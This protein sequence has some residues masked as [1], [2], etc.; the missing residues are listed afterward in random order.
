M[1]LWMVLLLVCNAL[2]MSP[3]AAQAEFISH[4]LTVKVNLDPND[5]TSTYSAYLTHYNGE[6]WDAPIYPV[7]DQ[8]D[9]TR[10]FSG[11]ESGQQY[12]LH[13]DTTR[14]QDSPYEYYYYFKNINITD[15]DLTHTAELISNQNPDPLYTSF[16]DNNFMAGKVAG[17]LVWG[18]PSMEDDSFSFYQVYFADSSGNIIPDVPPVAVRSKSETTTINE[19][20]GYRYMVPDTDIP[21]GAEQLR[22]YKTSSLD[23]TEKKKTPVFI[24]LRDNPGD[25]LN[26]VR[27]IDANKEPG[28]IQ[29]TIHW[30]KIGNESRI[31]HYAIY[32]RQMG[33]FRQIGTVRASGE[34]SYSL[35]LPNEY[36]VGI[37]A[38][39][40]YI[41]T[42]DW[43]GV[44]SYY[45][46]QVTDDTSSQTNVSLDTNPAIN[47]PT[48]VELYD[49][50]PDP[51]QISGYLKWNYNT[52]V[53]D[54]AFAIYFMDDNN[55]VLQSF[56]NI[57][58]N[59]KAESYGM[60]IPENIDLP[61]GTKK[62]GVSAI[63]EEGLSV[64][65]TV[66][67]LYRSA[68]LSALSTDVAALT[69]A[70]SSSTLSYS[71]T[72]ASNVYS[73]TVT[74]KAEATGAIVSVRGVAVAGLSTVSTNV[75]LVPGINVVPVLVTAEDG[76]TKTMYN[77][78]I[79]RAA[80]QLS[81]N[82]Q[83]SSLSLGDGYSLSPSFAK[84]IKAYTTTVG[85]QATSITV[86]AAVYDIHS[87]VSITY[88]GMSSA[89]TTAAGATGGSVTERVYL[90]SPNTE[91]KVNV[92][93]QNGSQGQYTINVQKPVITIKGGLGAVYGNRIEG[94]S[95]GTTVGTLLNHLTLQ[96]GA[97]A[98]V[99]NKTTGNAVN[100]YTI[101][102]SGM[103]L[104]LKYESATVTYELR[105]LNEL[106]KELTGMKT[107]DKFQVNQ[108]VQFISPTTK[109]DITGDGNFNAEDVL[110]ALLEISPIQ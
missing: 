107:G 110:K 105:T 19:T 84:D 6:S 103:N 17:T 63:T 101:L 70:F 40:L 29:P 78:T 66:S 4:S 74:A 52:T 60:N 32:E 54:N 91:I 20:I 100:D 16:F 3:L 25:L 41:A 49:M 77:I 64:P 89:A 90:N 97:T 36:Q 95:N 108:L 21:A 55:H 2:V 31:S 24:T 94:I 104:V 98:K 87:H 75:N 28:I 47:V 85:N 12:E 106:L 26:D 86:R 59:Y 88:P 22:F 7:N 58:F 9:G 93:A 68:K 45:Q 76:I 34:P 80:E 65:G 35:M 73:A 1:A 38:P 71:A 8:A 92:V 48:K 23:S 67:P 37:S 14:V 56:R 39:Y 27:M 18:Y 102:D 13:V 43:Q 42:L 79:T 50:N 30:S 44:A 33:Y 5:T 99:F 96:S 61:A 69:P 83:L 10:V 72:V 81:S 46:I 51:N 82:T 15:R 62:I 109:R 53:Y 57:Y 11:L